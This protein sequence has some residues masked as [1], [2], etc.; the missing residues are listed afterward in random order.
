MLIRKIQEPIA[1]V[2][3]ESQAAEEALFL[4]LE[5]R[6]RLAPALLDCAVQ[7]VRDGEFVVVLSDHDSGTDVCAWTGAADG[8][9][10]EFSA[11]LDRKFPELAR[12]SA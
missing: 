6:A 10:V 2:S 9:L 1:A 11:W 4:R 5:E 3:R 8:V 7:E 12:S